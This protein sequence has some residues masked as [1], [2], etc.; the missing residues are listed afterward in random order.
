RRGLLLQL[1]REP[2]ISERAR[3][4]WFE[5]ER[6]GARRRDQDRRTS[7]P[8]LLHGDTVPSTGPVLSRDAASRAS[9]LRRGSLFSAKVAV[10]R[11][12]L[13]GC[14]AIGRPVARGLLAGKAGSHSLAAVL[15]RA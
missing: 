1:R 6:H 12:G 14:G 5:R 10:K 8:S 4:A 3:S 2:G 7:R 15:A 9:W 13:I 11:V